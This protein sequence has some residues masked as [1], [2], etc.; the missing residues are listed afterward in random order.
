MTKSRNPVANFGSHAKRRSVFETDKVG[1]GPGAYD[2]A[3]KKAGPSF[4][5]RG[6]EHKKLKSEVPGPGSYQPNSNYVK[7]TI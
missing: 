1:L 6:K 4:T 5:M 3:N 7:S 2:L